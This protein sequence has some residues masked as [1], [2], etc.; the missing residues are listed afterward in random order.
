MFISIFVAA[1]GCLPVA[2]IADATALT[3][4]GYVGEDVESILSRL[5]QGPTQTGALK[6]CRG[7]LRPQ[8]LQVDPQGLDAPGALLSLAAGLLECRPRLVALGLDAG[9]GLA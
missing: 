8:G 5:L 2:S 7:H 4:A 6:R 9:A 1:S 3:E